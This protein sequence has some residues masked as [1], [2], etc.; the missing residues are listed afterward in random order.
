VFW[1]NVD[2]PLYLFH[3]S[4]DSYDYY[5]MCEY[6]AVINVEV[7]ALVSR[8]TAERVD[9][10]AHPMPSDFSKW[11]WHST[12]DGVYSPTTRMAHWLCCITLHSR[13]AVEF[14]LHR[15]H[16]LSRRFLAKEIAQWPFCEAFIPIEMLNNDFVVRALSDFGG[17][18]RYRW[19]PP[20]HEN[21]LPSLGDGNFV[22]PVLDERRY[23][24]SCIRQ[25]GASAYFS[26]DGVL[27][28]L[29]SRC[30][31][32]TFLPALREDLERTGDWGGLRRI[33]DMVLA[34]NRPELARLVGLTIDD[35][36]T[37][38]GQDDPAAR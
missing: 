4:H 23:A 36:R 10:V 18:E 9:Y 14:L 11:F 34:S 13:Q 25:R 27:R 20:H 15:R 21:D 29:L 17:T 30:S 2:Y 38:D 31:P 12:C 28:S 26:G 35:G 5:V 8:A 33:R 22:H 19:W 1:Y 6:D 7:D 3:Q 16:E 24:E 37:P 32:H